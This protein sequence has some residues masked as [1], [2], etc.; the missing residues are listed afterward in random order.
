M[1]IDE[2][3][4]YPTPDQYL[5][6]R[7]RT[8]AD[9]E[10]IDRRVDPETDVAELIEELRLHKIELELR[11][12]EQLCIKEQLAATREHFANLFYQAPVGYLA[13]D[14]EG[15]I[16]E[17][18]LKASQVLGRQRREL[19]GC[20][21]SDF[22][23]PRS[24][25]LF[26]NHLQSAL[27]TRQVQ[28][29]ELMV[30]LPGGERRDIELKS[31]SS[32]EPG[33]QAPVI[34]TILIDIGPQKEAERQKEMLEQQ[35]RQAH[36]MEALGRLAGGIA[37]DFNNLLTLIIGYSK[38]ALNSMSENDAFHVHVSQINKAG[39]HAAELI[40]Q[41]LSFSRNH[42]VVPDLIDLN[43]LIED[44]STML[45]RITGDDIE[46]TLELS[47]QLGTV[48]VDASQ[49]KQVLLNLA[50][51]AREA[52]PSGGSLVIRTRNT[53]L[54]AAA[55]RSCDIEPGS[56]VLLEVQDNGCG[57]DEETRARIFEP[58][59]TTKNE[60]KGN[61]F[62]LATTYGIISQSHGYIDVISEPDRG[63]TFLIYLPRLEEPASI[64]I[65]EDIG[66]EPSV[67]L[68]TIL[69]V[70]DQPDL[71]SYAAMVLR[72]YD[73]EVL[74]A[75]GPQDALKLC[76]SHSSS[77]ELLITDVTMPGMGGRELVERV[78]KLHPDI[79]VIYMSGH[80]HDVVCNERGVEQD[81][82]FLVKP[83][84]PEAIAALVREILDS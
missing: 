57:M 12:A 25:E 19:I 71:S 9:S 27:E 45:T 58:F 80:G 69:L 38:L 48:H 21:L 8:I 30:S 59:F 54:H 73:Y 37:H 65:H 28:T 84:T 33:A 34:R 6:Q 3:D 62:G 11:H 24:R 77:I 79:R 17:V 55:A 78:R 49:F 23:T 32:K 16:D 26:I 67:Q 75:L 56:Y 35:L 81:A 44:M 60:N 61:G 2:S 14:T 7:A 53:E 39:N 47:P 76:E 13:L 10:P 20:L 72:E 22:L 68:E 63:T 74:T 36:K 1:S 5:S 4:L 40:D 15:S 18:N 42:H 52:M 82:P 66:A 50:V 41:L 43:L 70:D 83:F 51:N 46:L 64:E 31:I 29:C